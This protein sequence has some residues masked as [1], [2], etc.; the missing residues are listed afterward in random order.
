M[1]SPKNDSSDEWITALGDRNKSHFM[2][3]KS[4]VRDRIGGRVLLQHLKAIS[5]YLYLHILNKLTP[6]VYKVVGGQ[7]YTVEVFS[8]A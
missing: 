4:S 2:G 1:G 3:L 6:T 8:A 7:N 5:A